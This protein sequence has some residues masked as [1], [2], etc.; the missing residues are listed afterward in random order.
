M[1]SAAH[2]CTIV[3]DYIHFCENMQ[4][5]KI[6]KN[7]RIKLDVEGDTFAFMVELFILEQNI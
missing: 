5:I 3:H 2:T 7:V 1:F 6:A 4:I